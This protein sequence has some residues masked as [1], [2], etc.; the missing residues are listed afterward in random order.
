[1][2]APGARAALVGAAL[3]LAAC[4][5]NQP[6]PEPMTVDTGLTPVDEVVSFVMGATGT[7]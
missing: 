2:I 4:S 7:H 1:M 5:A 3:V 6:P